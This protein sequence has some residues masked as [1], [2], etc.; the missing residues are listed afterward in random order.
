MKDAVVV[1]VTCP[2]RDEAEELARKTLD[3]RLA[4]CVTVVDGLKTFLHR[5]GDIGQVEGSLLILRTQANIADNLMNFV[6]LHHSSAIPDC[7]AV[8]V[9]A[10]TDDHLGWINAETCD[11]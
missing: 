9:I 2:T 5:D 8:P 7:I 3:Q 4:A 11:R 10:G 1:Y 6:Q